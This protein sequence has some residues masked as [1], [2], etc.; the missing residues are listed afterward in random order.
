MRELFLQL[1]QPIARGHRRALRRRHAR[2]GAEVAGDAIEVEKSIFILS[3][4][5]SKAEADAR[6]LM[7]ASP[8]DGGAY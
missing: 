5:W 1:L 8:V 6:F 3:D 7:P 2:E 4:V